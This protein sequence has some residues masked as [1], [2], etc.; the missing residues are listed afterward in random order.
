M[1]SVFASVLETI[2]SVV[3]IRYLFIRSVKPDRRTR[4][5]KPPRLLKKYYSITHQYISGCNCYT[6]NSAKTPQHHIFYFHGGAYVS[7]ARL[8]HWYAIDYFL[9][10]VAC[11]VTFVDYPLAPTFNCEDTL[12]ATLEIYQTISRD[13]PITLMG[14]SAGGGLC[15]ALAQQVQANQIK[16]SPKN[17]VLLSPW[18]DISMSEE[19]TRE[20]RKK[21]KMLTVSGLKRNGLAYAG[22]KDVFDPLCS[23]L[24]GNLNDL[25]RILIFTGSHDLIALDSRRLHARLIQE[26]IKHSF[27]EYPEMQHVFMLAP[28]PEGIDALKKAC[29]FIQDAD[30]L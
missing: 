24:F 8:P 28:I 7:K 17:L 18:L 14:D 25:S 3:E 15:L 23:P 20:M 22:N 5:S 11:Q 2:A 21:D 13:L 16:P 19:Y 4:F 12:S 1:K 9:K 30:M 6:L 10:H 27:F 29:A 26:N